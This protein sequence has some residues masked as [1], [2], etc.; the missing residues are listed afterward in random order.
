MNREILPAPSCAAAS[1]SYQAELSSDLLDAHGHLIDLVINF[2]FETLGANH[3]DLRVTPSGRF[4]GAA[5]ELHTRT[6]LPS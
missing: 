6:H 5:R 2:A 3:V 4:Q 1:E